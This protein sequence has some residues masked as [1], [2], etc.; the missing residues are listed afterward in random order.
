MCPLFL[1]FSLPLILSLC[2][3]SPSC[4]THSFAYP[5]PSSPLSTYPNTINYDIPHPFGCWRFEDTVPAKQGL[6][7][8]AQ[9]FTCMVNTLL[10]G[11]GPRSFT[12]VLPRAAFLYNCR[13]E[14]FWWKLCGSQSPEDIQKNIFSTLLC[15]SCPFS[16][17]PE[18]PWMTFSRTWHSSGDPALR[19]LEH[20]KAEVNFWH[21]CL[22]REYNVNREFDTM[23]TKANNANDDP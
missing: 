14:R 18:L 4:A 5:L 17:G 2:P 3:A 10:P 7:N 22:P 23:T 1:S 19:L 8:T 20:S 11:T 15:S 12:Y 6:A 9:P 13:A 21:C 16:I